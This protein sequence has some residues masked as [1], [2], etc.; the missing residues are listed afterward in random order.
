M[1]RKGQKRNGE[2][3]QDS[4]CSE[5]VCTFSNIKGSKIEQDETAVT[6]YS[7]FPAA[8]LKNVVGLRFHSPT[9]AN[10]Q[11]STTVGCSTGLT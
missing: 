5:M 4:D 1:E 3:K 6:S 2:E 8:R 11:T 9:L 10:A 7:L